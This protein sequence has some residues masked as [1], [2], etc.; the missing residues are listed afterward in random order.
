MDQPHK[1]YQ[2]STAIILFLVLF[3][4]V[5][6]YLM[7]KYGKWSSKTKWIITGIVFFVLIIGGSTNNSEK[8]IPQSNQVNKQEPVNITSKA[9]QTTS[10]PSPQPTRDQN[11]I[12]YDDA[13]K[14]LLLAG[15]DYKLNLEK[16]ENTDK[17]MGFIDNGTGNI[18][19]F[20]TKDNITDITIN[21]NKSSI[22]KH[23]VDLPSL[24]DEI[25]QDK[26]VAKIWLATQIQ[27]F[28]IT[29]GEYFEETG[30]YFH[31]AKK[32]FD[33]KDVWIMYSKSST[34]DYKTS[35]LEIKI[36]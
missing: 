16:V 18:N 13:R 27:S 28:L 12:T 10:I 23:L 2:N 1:W 9:V 19:L 34:S 4:P 11:K 6:L 25:V 5:G 21:L 35:T 36:K 3:F 33:N 20:G 22:D 15:L 32:V 17:Y 29:Q 31:E 24:L 7:W 14:A 26:G 30:L 8:K